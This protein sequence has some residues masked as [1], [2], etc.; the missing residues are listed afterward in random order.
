MEKVF[1]IDKRGASIV[2]D[3]CFQ[4]SPWVNIKVAFFISEYVICNIGSH[5]QSKSINYGASG[6]TH[7]A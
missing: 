4:L 3:H 1:F 2:N 5:E 6:A 7:P